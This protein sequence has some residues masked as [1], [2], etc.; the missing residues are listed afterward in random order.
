MGGFY[1]L[2]LLVYCD[3]ASLIFEEAN[4]GAGNDERGY[5]VTTVLVILCVTVLIAAFSS[6]LTHNLYP[7]LVL[8]VLCPFVYPIG[9]KIQ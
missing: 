1:D 5:I 8:L 7:G 2:P 9:R 3:S 4:M 6:L